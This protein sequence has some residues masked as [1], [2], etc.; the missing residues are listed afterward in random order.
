MAAGL[1]GEA[2]I[3][4]LPFDSSHVTLGMLLPL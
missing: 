3:P 4:D 1:S 2:R